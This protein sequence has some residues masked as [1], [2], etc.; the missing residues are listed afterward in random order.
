MK[1]SMQIAEASQGREEK[2]L[3]FPLKAYTQTYKEMLRINKKKV[4]ILNSQAEAVYG[5]DLCIWFNLENATG[6]VANTGLHFAQLYLN[7]C[8]V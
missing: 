2:T 1:D 5:M 7:S 3:I 6:T 4:S 8:S